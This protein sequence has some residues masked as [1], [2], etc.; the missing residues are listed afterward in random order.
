MSRGIRGHGAYAPGCRSLLL[1][2]APSR[3][4]PRRHPWHG[5]PGRPVRFV[6]LPLL[7]VAAVH[8]H[9]HMTG[10]G[11]QARPS[12]CKTTPP[13]N[14]FKRTRRAAP[15]GRTPTKPS[16]GATASASS[17]TAASTEANAGDR[18]L[19]MACSA[20]A[21]PLLPL[22]EAVD[23]GTH[24]CWRWGFEGAVRLVTRQYR[25]IR[26][27]MPSFQSTCTLIDGVGEL[28]DGHVY[29][30][31]SRAGPCP[32]PLLGVC[33]RGSERLPTRLPTMMRMP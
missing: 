14:R 27:R 21:S 20:A 26:A 30:S 5:A 12:T 31:I 17:T 13:T 1:P 24:V 25:S 18:G 33:R 10:R 32:R 6:L 3:H 15:A 4:C 16:A 8:V 9:V 19:R 11:K 22:L 23:R 29:G 28:I 2:L 7:R